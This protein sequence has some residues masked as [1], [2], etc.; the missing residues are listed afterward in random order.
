MF[1]KRMTRRTFMTRSAAA[2]SGLFLSSCFGER[3]STAPTPRPTFSATP[4]REVETRWPIKR[5]VY[6]MLE[7]RSFDNLFG[8]FPGANGT[9]TGVRWGQEVP[10]VHCPEWLPGDLLH[11]TSAWTTCYNG[12]AMD[13]F[14]IG[15]YGAYFAYSQFGRDDIP[16]YY[17]WAEDFVLCDHVFASQAGPSYPNH[18]FLIA[19]QAGGAVDNPENILTKHLNDGRVFKSWGCDAYG[20]DVYVPVLDEAGNVTQHPSCFTFDT[21]GEQ[22]SSRD[23][24]WAFYSA[25]PYQAGYIWQAYSA[26]KDVYENEELWDEHIWPVDDLL[27]DIE[28]GTLPPVTWVTPRYQLSDH[29]PFSTK[30]AH[31]WVTDIVNGIMRG[32]MWDDVAIFVT[33]D[34]WGGLYDHVAP[35]AVGDGAL[36]FRVPMLVISPYAKRGYIDDAFAEF[37]AP[38][39]FIE[40]NWGLPHLTK[41]IRDSHNFEH[42]FDFHRNP[43]NPEPRSKVEATNKFWDWPEHFAEWPP[44]LI[45]PQPGIRY[46]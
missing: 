4:V 17:G 25:D 12:G 45:P 6:L 9:T 35:P 7:N 37:S 39:R 28:A 5:V 36:G 18:L 13:G 20:D 22:L 23:I 10:I 46:P 21:V 31:N 24:D 8:R 41:R 1:P 42:V 32:P 38:L 3:V 11:D 16:N 44:G 34:E 29:P 2:A 40:D 26:I 14:A 33:W 27:R 19:G 43:R 30:H 15:D